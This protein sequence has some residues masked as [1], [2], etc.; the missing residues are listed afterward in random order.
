MLLVVMTYLW[1]WL[2]DRAVVSHTMN[3]WERD[4]DARLRREVAIGDQQYGF[5]E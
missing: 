5:I 1:R 2:A 3:I 4:V